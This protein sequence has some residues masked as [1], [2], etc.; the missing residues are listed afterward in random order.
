MENLLRKVNSPWYSRQICR[1]LYIFCPL[2][3]IISMSRFYQV[4]ALNKL[5]L[6][7]IGFF[8]NAPRSFV[9]DEFWRSYEIIRS[10]NIV[11]LVV[12]ISRTTWSNDH[13]NILGASLGMSEM[14][15]FSITRKCKFDQ[16][17]TKIKV[18]ASLDFD[19]NETRGGSE[20]V[21][22]SLFF[23]PLS[24]SFSFVLIFELL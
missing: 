9:L 10:P 18:V 24:T 17:M 16:L 20:L 12:N 7:C 3:I 11:L 2:V 6:Q 23:C 14:H 15:M 4:V 22:V 19:R 21:T 5:R 13:S 1:K 8:W